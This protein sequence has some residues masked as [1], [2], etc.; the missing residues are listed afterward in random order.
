MATQQ[1]VPHSHSRSKSAVIISRLRAH[2]SP[3]PLSSPEDES[4][5]LASIL[6]F[7]KNLIEKQPKA[8]RRPAK[9]PKKHLERA[10]R[11]LACAAYGLAQILDH[12]ANRSRR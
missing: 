4:Q 2:R 7:P 9:R 3:S 10:I 11:A 6:P 5:K 1:N 8:K 12:C